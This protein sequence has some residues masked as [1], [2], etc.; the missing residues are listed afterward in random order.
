M[1][2]LLLGAV[3]LTGRTAKI[4][5]TLTDVLP[6]AEHQQVWIIIFYA[7]ISIGPFIH[8]DSAKLYLT[9]LF[10]ASHGLCVANINGFVELSTDCG[11]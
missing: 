4:L 6:C 8:C 1:A 5:L 3:M 11:Q 10:S 7:A 9:S 2:I